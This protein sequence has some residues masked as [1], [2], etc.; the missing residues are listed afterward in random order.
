MPTPEAETC[1]SHAFLRSDRDQEWKL[2][3][4]S[5]VDQMSRCIERLIHDMSALGFS[6]RDLFGTRLALEEAVVNALKHGH[7]SDTNKSVTIRY[8]L[9]PERVI[10]E[11]EDQG[12]GFQPSE[13]PDP[14]LAEN[15]ERASG[16]GILL[17]RAFMNVVRFS[18]RGNRVTL[19]KFS[20]TQS[21]ASNRR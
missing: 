6:D 5:S 14:T 12:L 1:P 4:V 7:R 15:L 21:A 8:S 18:E 19:S 2:A 10:V 11:V 20:S 17:M 16:R 13:V 9:T 3:C